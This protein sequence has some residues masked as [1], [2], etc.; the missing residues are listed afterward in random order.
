M[1]ALQNLHDLKIA[2]RD[3]KSENIVLDASGHLVLVDFGMARLM[4]ESKFYDYPGTIHMMAPEILNRGGH[5]NGVDWWSLGVLIY[6]LLTGISPFKLHDKEKDIVVKNRILKE[7]PQKISE[8]CSDD[9][10]DLID[11]LLT[12]TASERLGKFLSLIFSEKR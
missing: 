8:P 7:K 3:L 2:H 12:K 9:I 11:K 10:K 5:G 4:T 6:E 1:L